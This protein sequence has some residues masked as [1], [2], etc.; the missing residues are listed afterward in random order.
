MPFKWAKETW[1]L[2]LCYSVFLLEKD[3]V[4]VLC[5]FSIL[6]V[7]DFEERSRSLKNLGDHS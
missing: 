6:V 1:S 5:S 7:F 2:F 4:S 3:I